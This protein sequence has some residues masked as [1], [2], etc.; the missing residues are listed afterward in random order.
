MNP[1]GS[2]NPNELFAD[3]AGTYSLAGGGQPLLA[4]VMSDSSE[5]SVNLNAL[6]DGFEAD[7]NTGYDSLVLGVDNV[8]TLSDTSAIHA[9]VTVNLSG[10]AGGGGGSYS[11]L[12]EET[13]GAGPFPAGTEIEFDSN[14]FPTMDGDDDINDVAEPDYLLP[15][16]KNLAV[17]RNGIRVASDDYIMVSGAANRNKLKF[18]FALSEDDHLMVEVK[19]DP[20]V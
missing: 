8:L 3:G 4:L 5:K 9:D 7:T 10:L 14:M 20:A 2:L 19:A 16:K 11:D 15:W 18:T 17:Y 6:L 12:L 13:L 1:A